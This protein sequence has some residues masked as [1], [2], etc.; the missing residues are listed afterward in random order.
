MDVLEQERILKE[1]YNFQ[2]PEVVGEYMA[3]LIPPGVRSICEPTPGIGTLVKICRNRGYDVTAPQDYFQMEKKRFD[4]I[5]GNPPFSLKYLICDNAPEYFKKDGM[6]VGYM[7]LQEWMD[8]SDNVIVVMPVFTLIDSDKRLERIMDF[9]LRSI[10]MLPRKTFQYAR[11][12]TCV[13]EF[14]KGFCGVTAFRRFPDADIKV[15]KLK[16]F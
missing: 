9:G 4:A 12:Q 1:G 3:D 15:K 8:M 14:N 11:I 2:T 10:T 16:L 7:L 5:V 13:L 6:R